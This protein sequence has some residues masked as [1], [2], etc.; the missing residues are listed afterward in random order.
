MGRDSIMC[1]LALLNSLWDGRGHKGHRRTADPFTVEGVRLTMGLAVQPDVVRA[2][3]ENSKGPAR[4]FGF[5]A[6][7]L[8]AWPQST[9]G[10]RL[11]KP[12]PKLGCT[13]QD[14]IGALARC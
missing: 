2:Y 5:A 4:G 7:F 10:T 1:N 3:F 9:Q 13:Y 12:A 11:F 8:I 14:S 6:R